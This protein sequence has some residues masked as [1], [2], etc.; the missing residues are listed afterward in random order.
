[1]VK[2]R[3]A[4]SS[5]NSCTP[6]SLSTPTSRCC[7]GA[8]TFSKPAGSSKTSSSI[9]SARLAQTQNGYRTTRYFGGSS[10]W[11]MRKS[12]DGSPKLSVQSLCHWDHSCPRAIRGLSTLSEDS[13][14]YVQSKAPFP[15]FFCKFAHTSQVP[16]SFNQLLDVTESTYRPAGEPYVD[17]IHS[18]A[19]YS[20]HAAIA[21]FVL[22]SLLGM[23]PVCR[24]FPATPR[25]NWARLT[26][27][28]AYCVS[29]F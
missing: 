23:S 20:N 13:R 24:V 25:R 28:G 17:A 14:R 1:M 3:T 7:L 12:G 9:L 22:P 21:M 5:A 29:H 27:L 15:S 11:M 8:S 16:E 4:N 10:T 26:S 19:A 6:L 2:T 18:N